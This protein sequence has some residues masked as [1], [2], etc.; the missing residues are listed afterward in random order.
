M[1]LYGMAGGGILASGVATRALFALLPGLLLLVATVGFVWRDPSAQQAVLDHVG[2][3]VPPVRELLADSVR[4]IADGALQVTAIGLAALVW[5]ASGFFQTL[6][7]TFAVVLD[8]PRRRHPLLR[9][10]VGLVGVVLVL[11][12]ISSVVGVGLLASSLARQLLGITVDGDL[13]RLLVLLGTTAIVSLAVAAAYRFIPTRRA[14]WTAIGLPATAVGF[15]FAILTELFTLVAPS[16]AGIASLYGAIA[17]IFV[18]L[19]WLQLAAQLVVMGMVW[20][21]IRADGGP[22]RAELPWP[23]GDR[24]RPRAPTTIE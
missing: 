5:A 14:P 22:S 21:R 4:V 6:E 24:D 23:T 1:H 3:F 19:A 10:V 12:A 20:V 2:Q 15:G 11:A 7:V 17:A 8:E 16:L 9:S 13:A 18:L